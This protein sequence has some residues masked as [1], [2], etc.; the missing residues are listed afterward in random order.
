MALR[1]KKTLPTAQGDESGAPQPKGTGSITTVS[2]ARHAGILGI[3]AY[4]PRRV[5]D[6][7]EICEVLD[8][9]DEWI[10]ERSGIINIGIEGM[11]LAG[12]FGAFVVKAFTGSILFPSQE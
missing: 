3:G 9:S 4:R 1:R 5:V 12:A 6:N 7:H 10:R 2:G 8:S 11:M